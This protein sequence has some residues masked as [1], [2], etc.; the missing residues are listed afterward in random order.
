MCQGERKFLASGQEVEIIQKLDDGRFL[1]VRIYEGSS[2]GHESE[3]IGDEEEVVA[4]LFDDAPT[5]KYCAKID[6]LQ[7]EVEALYDRKRDIIQELKEAESQHKERMAKYH[8]YAGLE[9]LDEFIAGKI[10]HY[11]TDVSWSSPEIKTFDE[12][13]GEYGKNAP[14]LLSLFGESGGQLDWRINRYKDDSG[15]WRSCIP[16]LSYEEA[17]AALAALMQEKMQKDVSIRSV[18]ICDA[19]GISVPDEYREAVEQKRRASV[20]KAILE[21]TAKLQELEAQL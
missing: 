7:M 13:V 6:R 12:M 18:N 10:T 15:T 21:T 2:W 4:Q 9:H 1:V 3:F 11:V 8:N 17:V 16:C 20:E 14:R 19:H 5:E